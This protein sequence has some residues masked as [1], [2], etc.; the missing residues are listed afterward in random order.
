MATVNETVVAAQP[1]DLRIK[2]IQW[3]PLLQGDTG[4]GFELPQFA[5]R[6]VQVS[7][8]FG[9]ATVTFEG[10]NEGTAVSG[11]TNYTTLTDPQGNAISK[12]SAAIE[13]IEEITRF[14]RPKVTGGDGTT[15]LTVTMLCKSLPT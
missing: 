6:S 7:G 3:T 15:S 10:T 11:A 8:T 14:F 4:R 9:G 5:D 2:V 1:P 13:Q 12:T